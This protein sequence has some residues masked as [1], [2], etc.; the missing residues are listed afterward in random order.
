MLKQIVVYPY[1]GTLLG[2]EWTEVPVTRCN[3]AKWMD[4]IYIMLS[5][6]IQR[7]SCYI[8]LRRCKL[9]RRDRKRSVVALEQELGLGT[10]QPGR[11]DYKGSSR[12]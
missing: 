5:E 12:G 9:V 6:R 7:I 3:A 10:G 2:S 1:D 4:L 8:Q 11:R